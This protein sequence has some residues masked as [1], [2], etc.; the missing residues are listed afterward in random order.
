MHTSS[1]YIVEPVPVS[2]SP[3]LHTEP[4]AKKRRRKRKNSYAAIMSG[5]VNSSKPPLADQK[6]EHR[7]S[8][9]KNLGGGA[10]SKLD[11]I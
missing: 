6:E 11:R 10:F 1:S 3:T 9:R 7:H 2:V 4:P 5:I 8:L